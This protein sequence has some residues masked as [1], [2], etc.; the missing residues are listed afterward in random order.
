MA[1]RLRRCRTHLLAA[2][3]LVLGAAAPNPVIAQGGR[4]VADSFWSQALGHR[5]RYLVYLPR[6]YD[7]EATRRYPVAYYLHGL[8]GDETNWTKQGA[9][10]HT[11]DS[12]IAGGMPEMLVVMPDGDDSWYTTWNQL[13]TFAPCMQHPPPNEPADTYCVPWTHYDDY[14]AR[15][16]V[17]RIDST[18]RTRADRRHRAIAGL[19]MGGYGAVTLAFSYP[20]VFSAAVSHSGVLAPLYAGPHP[21][22]GHAT[23]ASDPAALRSWYGDAFFGLISLAFGRDTTGWWPRDPARIAERLVRRDAASVPAIKLDVGTADT[24]YVDQTRAFHAALQSLGVRH[25]YAE[26]PGD[27]NWAYWRRHAAESLT[28]IASLIGGAP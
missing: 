25:E 5:K 9:L 4:V 11:L 22:D 14:L 18:Y 24:K 23:Y 3:S 21:F 20:D 10:D 7:Q 12:L 1:F 27:H 6:S 8:W 2:A 16:V 19:S 15:D 26:Y 28:W 17:K 13:S